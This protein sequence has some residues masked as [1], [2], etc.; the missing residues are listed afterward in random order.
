MSHFKR[1]GVN[2]EYLHGHGTLSIQ[3]PIGW[4]NQPET[5]YIDNSADITI[6]SGVSFSRGVSILTHEHN[7]ARNVPIFESDVVL[8]PLTIEDDV[9]LGINVIVCAQVRRIGKGA[10]IGAGSVLTKSV[11]DYE[12]WAGNPARQIGIRR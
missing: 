4:G 11:G 3:K 7:H 6:G 5:I 2:I 8:I 9:Q 10:V 12:I 1:R